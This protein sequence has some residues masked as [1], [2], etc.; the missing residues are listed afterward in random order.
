MKTIDE[1]QM[2]TLS[3]WQHF[4][5]RPLNALKGVGPLKTKALKQLKLLTVQDLLFH[6][7]QRYLLYE[8]GPFHDGTLRFFTATIRSTHLGQKFYT[9]TVRVLSREP[10]TTQQPTHHSFPAEKGVLSATLFFHKK[11]ASYLKQRFRP[12][13]QWH[14]WGLC[15]QNE[16]KEVVFFHPHFIP[17]ATATPTPPI[18]PLYPETKGLNSA[19]HHRLIKNLFSLMP[20]IPEWH[21]RALLETKRWPSFTQ[22]LLIV[23]HSGPHHKQFPQAC[24]RLCC[25]RLLARQLY[26]DREKHALLQ[27]KARPLHTPLMPDTSSHQSPHPIR[28]DQGSH[29]SPKHCVEKGASL[30][31]LHHPQRRETLFFNLLKTQNMIPSSSQKAAIGDIA[32]DIAR[33]TPMRRLLQGDVGSGKTLVAFSALYAALS[34]GLRAAFLAPTTLLAQQVLETFCRLF[35]DKASSCLLVTRETS[36]KKALLEA[37]TQK[38]AFIAFGT[39]ALLSDKNKLPNLSLVVIDEQQ[40]FGVGQRLHLLNN[41][42]TPPDDASTALQEPFDLF[43]QRVQNTKLPKKKDTFSPHFLMMT[44]T[45]IPRTAHLMQHDYLAISYLK[46]RIESKRRTYV[47][48]SEK[49]PELLTLIQKTLLKGQKVF[50]LCAC[51]VESQERT[52]VEERFAH[53]N[54]HFPEKVTQLY[55]AQ[56]HTEKEK[57]LTQFK[58]NQT[59]ILVA[60]TVIEIGIDVADASLMIIEDATHFGLSQLHQLRG[61]IGRQG[62]E[63][64]C[65]LL[66]TPPLSQ[67]AQQRLRTLKKYDDGFYIAQKDLTLRGEGLVYGTR[68]SG[69]LNDPFLG[70][71][72]EHTALLHLLTPILC[73]ERWK[74]QWGAWLL[75]TFEHTSLAHHQHLKAG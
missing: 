17:G 49:I 21:E 28:P 4:L 48:R 33:T 6:L 10:D 68:Q 13:T 70:L 2:T 62:Q 32:R 56:P 55:G 47:M 23:H 36:G 57:N 54:A 72:S 63:S 35:K 74:K 30:T 67:K 37:F 40:R 64:H 39:H 9:V 45:P 38:K 41:P 43:T 25:D 26:V 19:A 50:W 71:V 5:T 14:L 27:E 3:E 58:T 66:Y 24:E 1:N 61:R 46:A 11:Q 42:H 15:R 53:L 8:P 22:A 16:K 44:A 51:V 52:S 60:T 73:N 69:F 18:T 31:P 12:E 29:L 20:S 65:V 75:N 34:S 7:P 59:P